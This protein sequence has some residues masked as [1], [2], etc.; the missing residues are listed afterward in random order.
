MTVRT[1]SSTINIMGN[2]NQVNAAAGAVVSVAASAT[3]P[4]DNVVTAR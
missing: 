1:G 4:A 3:G 2:H